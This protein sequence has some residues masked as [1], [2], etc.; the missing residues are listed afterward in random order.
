MAIDLTLRSV[1]GTPL[2]H[3]E[4]DGNFTSL[5][6]GI[7][8]SK[9]FATLEDFGG[10][11]NV[12]DNT[13]ALQA[14]LASG[15]K[16]LH[17][18]GDGSYK[19]LSS[20]VHNGNLVITSSPNSVVDCTSSSFS[21]QYWL[22]VQGSRTN[23]PSIA[24]SVSKGAS[25][26]TFTSS[27]GLSAGDIF[28][29]FNPTNSSWST[30][31]SVYFSGEFCEVVSVSGN[32]V[33][34]S[35]PLYSSYTNTAVNCYKINSS[36]LVVDGLNIRGD[37]S[38][39]LVDIEFG[40]NCSIRGLSSKH[41]NNS[42][43]QII[44][45]YNCV[46]DNPDIFNVGTGVNDDYGIVVTNSQT[47]KVFGGRVHSRRHGITTGGDGEICAVPCRDL[48]FEGVTISNDPASDVFAA[49]FHG[50]TEGAK[51]ARCK[52]Y[53]GATWQGRDN[54]YE[55]CEIFGMLNGVCIYSSEVVG[56]TLYARNCKMYSYAD[57]SAVSRGVVDIGGNNSA[58][59]NR[60]VQDVTLDL[61]GS[62][63]NGINFS[64]ITS[65][66]LMR[67]RGTTNKINIKIDDLD[68]KVNNLGQVLFTARD[69]GTAASDFIIVDNIRSTITAKLICNHNG[70]HYL[71]F[72]HKLQAQSGAQ[73]VNTLTTV[74]S[75]AGVVQNL[76]W[77]YPRIPTATVSAINTGFIGSKMPQAYFDS[78]AVTATAIRPWISTPDATNFSS[79]QSVTLQWQVT[80][81]EV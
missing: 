81:S 25:Q 48:L 13:S 1:K 30:F 24:S 26:I 60:T 43:L 21:G 16:W 12:S 8:N 61:T 18:G 3:S 49:D 32:T 20:T 22:K 71:N 9:N 31:R 74:N 65:M 46:V 33:Y 62:T 56:G 51:Y 70:D 53:G 67:N 28:I 38:T 59:D 14:L 5:R 11:I 76:K 15:A 45:S 80:I 77:Q 35:N 36:Q 55:D 19:F 6:Q 39:S 79:A 54:G 68:L 47:V 23:L 52:I 66:M 57:P 42:V 10:G 44:R 17:F 34:L 37:K 27:H 50:N 7:Y 73:I 78:G 4:L 40:R 41:K 58:I 72:P 29:V 63:I 2:T 69:S 64:A 75:V